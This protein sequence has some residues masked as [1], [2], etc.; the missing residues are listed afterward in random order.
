MQKC[1]RLDAHFLFSSLEPYM[2]DQRWKLVHKREEKG[3]IKTKLIPKKLGNELS[4]N[5]L[6]IPKNGDSLF[7][8]GYFLLK[9]EHAYKDVELSNKWFEQEKGTKIDLVE[10]IRGNKSLI[11]ERKITKAD[12]ESELINSRRMSVD[13]LDV[14]CMCNNS[15]ILYVI[16]RIV[17][18]LGKN[19][20]IANHDLKEINFSGVI[21]RNAKACGCTEELTSTQMQV[22]MDDYWV[23]FLP[24][25]PMKGITMY[26]VDEL[27]DICRRIKI[28]VSCPNGKKKTKKLLFSEIQV[29]MKECFI[30]N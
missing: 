7:W 4:E 22:Y 28:D 15:H 8:C 14:M 2:A 18:V 6:L 12:V 25:K 27:H 13:G 3:L 11:K 21:L 26:S 16:K 23:V 5:S 17:F 29:Y 1:A 10:Y 30:E 9:G 20:E 19:N 24:R